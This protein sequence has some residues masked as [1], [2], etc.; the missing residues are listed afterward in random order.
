VTGGGADIT[1][2]VGATTGVS[3]VLVVVVVVV[4][5][6]STGGGGWGGGPGCAEA[7]PPAAV[8]ASTRDL[9][10]IAFLRSYGV[11]WGSQAASQS[12]NRL[13]HVAEFSYTQVK[14]SSETSGNCGIHISTHVALPD[15]LVS[16]Q[17]H[18]AVQT[19]RARCSGGTVHAAT[20]KANAM[21]DIPRS[22]IAKIVPRYPRNSQIS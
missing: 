15:V 18:T 5:A 13:E 7:T 17:L 1:T 20:L 11:V 2:G 10:L 19:S 6:V 21:I 9:H 3:V 4:V 8:K 12:E 16:E 22:R 14:Q